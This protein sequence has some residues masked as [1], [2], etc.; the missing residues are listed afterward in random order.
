MSSVTTFKR[1]KNATNSIREEETAF[2]GGSDGDRQQKPQF[3]D[4]RFRRMELMIEFTNLRNPKHCPSG[5]YVMPSAEFYDVAPTIVF[6]SSTINNQGLFHPLV[7]AETGEFSLTQRFKDWTTHKYFIFHIL[8]YIKK[9]F[10]K[11]VLDNL[12]EKYCLG[13]DAYKLYNKDIKTFANMASQ[14]ANFS[15]SETVLF[16]NH[17]E[18]NPIQFSILP[19]EKKVEKEK[20]KS[21]YFS[22]RTFSASSMSSILNPPQ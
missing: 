10:K 3:R 8:H 11:E 15:R 20:E 17:T 14:S 4:E 22:R 5:V 21:S 18:A 7:H 1:S 9:S 16:E 12:S 19:K 13:I 6:P 2:K